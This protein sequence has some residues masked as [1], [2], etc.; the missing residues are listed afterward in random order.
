MYHYSKWNF[1]FNSLD[2]ESNKR[3]CLQRN[4]HLVKDCCLTFMKIASK[5]D[6]RKYIVGHLVFSRYDLMRDKVYTYNM[7]GTTACS[8]LFVTK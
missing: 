4:D 1:I 2:E 6:V 5:L 8:S 3:D 7:G